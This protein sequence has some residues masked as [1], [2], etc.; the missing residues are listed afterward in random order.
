[1]S[2]DNGGETPQA[3][4]SQRLQ[5]AAWFAMLAAMRGVGKEVV[6]D[7]QTGVL[8]ELTPAGRIFICHADS[9]GSSTEAGSPW[10]CVATPWTGSAIHD[11]EEVM[12]A[13][14]LLRLLVLRDLPYGVYLRT[15][16]WEMVR[17]K[18]LVAA[19]G[20]CGLCG[21]RRQDLEAHH[22]GYTRLG[23]EQPEDVIALCWRC[24]RAV[25]GRLNGMSTANGEH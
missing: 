23:L 9:N 15:T 11:L 2:W 12:H 6:R 21:R 10:L 14:T 13:S 7:I 1:M 18:V 4:D 25:H 19:G 16:H 8:A 24:H 20:V 3:A 5:G 22:R 17:R